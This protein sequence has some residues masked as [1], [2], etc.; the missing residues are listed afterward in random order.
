MWKNRLS[1]GWKT[2]DA[3]AL[4]SIWL[5]KLVHRHSIC[6]VIDG[7][8]ILRFIL[9]KIKVF[10]VDNQFA[11]WKRSEWKN[12]EN[13]VSCINDCI[14]HL[15][16]KAYFEYMNTHHTNCTL[17]WM[18][19]WKRQ[20]TLIENQMKHVHLLNFVFRKKK[21]HIALTNR[22]CTY[23]EERRIAGRIKSSQYKFLLSCCGGVISVWIAKTEE[24]LC[25]EVF[26]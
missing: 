22:T 7:L 10:Q 15:L 6:T 23:V 3:N 8:D 14:V 16:V 25:M 17:A 26:E 2:I 4:K 9:N 1:A 13:M 20:Y 11:E 24:N 19:S 21:K 5:G 12:I 18:W